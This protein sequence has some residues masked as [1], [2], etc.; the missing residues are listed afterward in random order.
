VGE[1]LWVRAARNGSDV[2]RSAL[3]LVLLSLVLACA[4]RAPAPP[5]YWNETLGIATDFSSDW[6][7]VTDRAT[8][9][10]TAKAHF[11]E[12]KG[13]D[14]SPL[15]LGIRKGQDAFARVWI[16][17]VPR[18][19]DAEAYFRFLI[20][21]L[22]SRV[23]IFEA[24]QA[25]AFDAVRWSY[26]DKTGEID[27]IYVETVTVRNGYG[28]RIGYWTSSAMTA[29]YREEFDQL[30]DAWM[31]RS[32][33]G[34]TW[35]PRWIGLSESLVPD[36]LEFVEIVDPLGRL[37]CGPDERQLL[38]QLKGP[39]GSLYLFGS[40]HLGVP[41]NYPLPE[42]IESAFL[43]SGS[44]IVEVDITAASVQREIARLMEELG[45][46][47]PG[48]H[49][50]DHLTPAGYERLKAALE[51]LGLPV[52][53]FTGLKPWSI[54]TVLSVLKLQSLGYWDR[55]GVDKY[56][57]DRAGPRDI[58]SIE[59][60]EEQIRL[61]DALDGELF[62]AFSLLGLETAEQLMRDLMRSWRCG[63]EEGLETL[64]ID[65][66]TM[67]LPDSRAFMQ[68][69]YYERNQRMADFAIRRL[70]IP[71]DQ[72]M[73]VGVAH[74]IGPRGIPQLLRDKGFEVEAR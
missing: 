57:L 31:F 53:T 15:L 41:S 24:R 67:A 74:L 66:P 22:G 40:V 39:Q 28:V 46:L 10:I 29:L 64:L 17:P 6:T 11:P 45:S 36:G 44:L 68:V 42:P 63:D 73:V 12:N 33:A 26:R 1:G 72:F 18:S 35:Q 38:W 32:D 59:S 43:R 9:P 7:I 23:D 13:P 50:A 16:E 48:G 8:A 19:W 14:D 56:F 37:P 20:R 5:R 70:A 49:V 69:M 27:L 60:A 47:P 30:A 2:W 52:R 55:Y 71:G 51:G 61:L 34:A 58:V 62:L 54:A 21:T 3:A 25:R 65:T 4:T